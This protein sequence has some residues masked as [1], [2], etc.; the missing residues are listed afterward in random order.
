M[1]ASPCLEYSMMEKLQRREFV[2][3]DRTILNGFGAE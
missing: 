1:S 2:F 3:R